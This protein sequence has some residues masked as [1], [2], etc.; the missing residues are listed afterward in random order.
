MWLNGVKYL[1]QDGV[2]YT[3]RDVPKKAPKGVRWSVEMW[4][5]RKAPVAV[6]RAFTAAWT[7]APLCGSCGIPNTAGA[8][9]D[10]CRCANALATALAIAKAKVTSV[11]PASVEPEVLPEV[12]KVLEVLPA[13]PKLHL[14]TIDEDN[15]VVGYKLN[16]DRVMTMIE[17]QLEKVG[18]GI[19]AYD[20]IMDDLFQDDM[21][22]VYFPGADVTLQ[23]FK[24]DVPGDDHD[25]F[26]GYPRALALNDSQKKALA[27]FHTMFS[28]CLDI[29]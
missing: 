23:M 20:Y 8:A 13:V 28:V 3:I 2:V 7:A 22:T 17:N 29:A 26:V 1:H 10:Y 9:C 25:F 18:S 27:D 19:D 16:A 4:K 14:H 6:Q 15:F 5:S 24:N 12:P 11:V 21:H